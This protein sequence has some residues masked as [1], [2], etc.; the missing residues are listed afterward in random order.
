MSYNVSYSSLPTL[1]SSSLGYTI[2]ESGNKTTA[3]TS[4]S[5]FFNIC[6]FSL[7][8]GVYM[9]FANIWSLITK[10]ETGRW[11]GG[12]STTNSTVITQYLCTPAASKYVSNPYY[13]SSLNFTYCISVSSGTTTL[14][15]NGYA[16]GSRFNDFDYYCQAIKIA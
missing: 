10:E 13:T 15:I 1:T 5:T 3:G 8:P 14:Y 6:S 9:V 16:D 7:T 12:V 4:G 2:T 11:Q